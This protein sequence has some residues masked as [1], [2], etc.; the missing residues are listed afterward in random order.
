MGHSQ[1]SWWV[2]ISR[3]SLQH[4][5]IVLEIN[6][7]QKKLKNSLEIKILYQIFRA[8]AYDPIMCQYFC[9]WFMDFVLKGKSL[10]VYTNLF[11]CY[12]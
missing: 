1:N 4:T 3:N 11:S 9:I 6:I 12:E 8:Q 7:F 2:S 5:L 10:L